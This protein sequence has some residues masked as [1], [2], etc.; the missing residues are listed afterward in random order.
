[1][2]RTASRRAGFLAGPHNSASMVRFF[3]DPGARAGVTKWESVSFVVMLNLF[4]HPEKNVTR[5]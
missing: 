5:T 1:M 2:E 4:Q 3:L